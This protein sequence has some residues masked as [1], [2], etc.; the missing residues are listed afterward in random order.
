MSLQWQKWIIYFYPLVSFNQLLMDERPFLSWTQLCLFEHFQKRTFLKDLEF[1][2]FW[3]TSI[4]PLTPLHIH[5]G[6][7]STAVGPWLCKRSKMFL[8][9]LI[10][11]YEHLVPSAELKVPILHPFRDMSRNI[12][13]KATVSLFAMAI[14]SQS[15]W[16]HNYSYQYPW[17]SSLI[18]S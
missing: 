8:V 3:M 2:S 5:V 10:G 16:L 17:Y 11:Q 6:P 9:C 1:L 14:L 15:L 12:W 4:I 7:S 13:G 18:K